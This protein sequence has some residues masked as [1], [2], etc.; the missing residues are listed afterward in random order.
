MQGVAPAQPLPQQMQQ[1][2]MQ[3]RLKWLLEQVHM[4]RTTRHHAS[5]NL[6]SGAC[7]RF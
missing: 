4:V 7:P 3:Q 1:Q 2:A 6:P 5:W